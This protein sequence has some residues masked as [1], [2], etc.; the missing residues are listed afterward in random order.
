LK[1][2][3]RRTMMTFACAVL[4]QAGLAPPATA[5]REPDAKIDSHLAQRIFEGE[6]KAIAQVA[7]RQPIFEA[8][9]QS[10]DPERG[11]EPSVDDAYF[12]GKLSLNPDAVRVGSP[13]R[14]AFGSTPESRRIRVNTGDRWP[15]Y[16][17]GYV[18]M[19]F[20][21][22]GDFDQD[23]YELTNESRDEVGGKPSLRFAVR[24]LHPE[25]SGRFVGEIW[26]DPI[27]FRIIR[28]A[29]TFS[30]KK[31][32]RLSKYFNPGGISRVGLYFHFDSWRQEVSPGLWLPS[33]TFFDEQRHFSEGD[34]TTSFHLRGNIWVWS[35]QPP[36]PSFATGS[37]GELETSGLLASPGKVEQTLT[38]II[39]EIQTANGLAQPEITCRVALTT[40]A[41]VFSID[42]TVVISRGLLNLLPDRLTLAGLL[43]REV[44]HI[45]LGH[46]HRNAAS[47]VHVFEE[48]RRADFQ[49]FGMYYSAGEETFALQKA[50]SLLKRTAYSGALNQV[51]NFLLQL[52]QHSPQIRHLVLPAFGPALVDRASL[53]A[54][55]SVCAANEKSSV[56]LELRGQYGVNSWQNEIVAMGEQN[57]A[58]VSNE[59][60]P[61][62]LLNPL[63]ILVAP[64]PQPRPGKS[65][66]RIGGGKVPSGV[67]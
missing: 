43:A 60:T 52:D 64:R 28:I 5:R 24:P 55:R 51:E 54:I 56:T 6:Q 11:P 18:D 59:I 31:L 41:E 63:S 2:K 26:V 35:Y 12:L 44:A 7:K 62:D 53:G 22:V 3:L 40:P 21:D 50:R 38:T 37:L 10:L 46:S 4:L 16:P 66:E 25:S 58:E 67:E 34:L 65:A 61:A 23:H 49:G 47:P 29:G 32:G 42:N 57:I 13:L 27:N 33:Y 1:R 20:V 45:L 19:L 14:L 17:D 39:Q 36:E 8:Y 9:V 30:P 15:L 48:T